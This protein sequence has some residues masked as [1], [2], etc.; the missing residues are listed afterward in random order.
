MAY[1]FTITQATNAFTITTPQGSAINVGSTA[2]TVSATQNGVLVIDNG[3]T[4]SQGSTGYIGSAGNQGYTGSAGSQG[5]AG[6]QGTTGYVGSQGLRGVGYP[7]ITGTSYQ[8][9]YGIGQTVS[10]QGDIDLFTTSYRNH[11]TV[12]IWTTQEYSSD[13]WIGTI[14]GVSGSSFG[15]RLVSV[16]GN[17]DPSRTTWTVGLGGA[18]GIQ[19][20]AGSQGA[21]GSTGTSI[22][23]KSSVASYSFLPIPGVKGD[24]YLVRDQGDLYY[25]NGSSYVDAGHIVGSQGYT[26]SAG[27]NGYTGSVGIGYVGSA[28]SY[29]QALYTTSSVTFAGLTLNNDNVILGNGSGLNPQTN[30]IAIGHQASFGGAQGDNTIAIGYQSGANQNAYA[31]AIGYQ[32]GNDNQGANA[33]AIGRNAGQYQQGQYA[34]AIGTYDGSSENAGAGQGEYS[35][36]IGAAAGEFNQGSNAVAIGLGAGRDQQTPNSIILNASGVPFNDSGNSGFYVN[37]VRSDN[38]PTDIIYFNSTTGELTYGAANPANP[39]DQVLYTTSSVTFDSVTATNIIQASQFRASNGASYTTGYSFYTETD[40]STG[41]YSEV[42]GQVSIYGYENPIATFNTS[43]IQLYQPLKFPDNTIQTSAFSGNLNGGVVTYNTTTHELIVNDTQI[44]TVNLPAESLLVLD[45]ATDSSTFAHTL[46]FGNSATTSGAINDPWS[47]ETPMLFFPSTGAPYVEV[48]YDN[49]LNF[50]ADDLTI[51]CWIYP[52]AVGND[53]GDNYSGI[54]GAWGYGNFM[55]LLNSDGLIYLFDAGQYPMIASTTQPPLNDWTHIA[56]T[57]AN[58][59]FTLWINGVAEGTYTVT[60]NDLTS[61][62]RLRIGEQGSDQKSFDGYITGVRMVDKVALYSTTFTPPV[63]GN[64]DYALHTYVGTTYT[65]STASLITSGII[66]PDSTV[67]TTAW[68]TATL[69]D[70]RFN[71]SWIRNKDTGNIYISPQDGQTWLYLPS[72]TDATTQAVTLSNVAGGGIQ[73]QTNNHIWQFNNNGS[74]TFPSQSTNNRTGSGDALVFARDGAGQKI[75]ATQS[76]DNS[77]STVERLVIAG[78]DGYASGEGGDIYLWA[79]KSG[80]TGGTGG[81]IKVDAGDAYDSQGGTV[82]IRGGNVYN[83]DNSIPGEGGFIQILAGHSYNGG[84]GGTITLAAGNGYNG[85]DNGKVIIQS[86]TGNWQFNSDGSITFPDNTTQTSAYT[87]SNN[88]FDQ[89]L[90]TTDIPTFS[91]IILNG[92]VPLRLGLDAGQTNQGANSIAIGYSAGGTNQTSGAVAIGDGAGSLNQGAGAVA[93]G[94]MAGNSAQGYGGTGQGASSVAIG[95]AAGQNDQGIYSVAI[96]PYAG[97]GAGGASQGNYSI[98]I[99]N[100]AGYTNQ[101][102]YS[103]A[104]GNDA[105]FENQTPNSIILNA[106]G[107]PFNDSGNAGFYVNPIRSATADNVIYFDSTTNELTY[108]TAI[109]GY[110]GSQGDI[111]YVGSQGDQ[112]IPGNDGGQGPQGDPG[113]VGSQGDIGYVGSQGDVGYVGSTGDLGYTGSQ[114]TPG[115]SVRI[116]GSAANEAGLSPFDPIPVIGDGVITT[117]TGHLWVYDGIQFNDVGNVTGPQG[118]QGYTGSQGDIGYVGSQGNIGY[119]GSVGIGYVGSAGGNGTNGYTG[120]QGT[121]GGLGYTGSKGADG[122][123]GSNGATGYTGSVGVGYVGSAG[124]NGSGNDT[125]YTLGNVSGTITPSLSSGTVH[126]YTLTGNIT[127]NSLT[128]VT[129]GSSMTLILTQDATGSRTLTSSMKWAG[130]GFKT[131]STAGTSTDIVSIFYDGSTYWASLSKGF[132]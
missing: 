24:L 50:G 70:I 54:I 19:G 108:G 88:P 7:V 27:T 91:T 87:G 3:Y 114:G 98:A 117:D 55:I 34:I 127:L 63:P 120:S 76:G 89:S 116:L 16:I 18:Q 80:P 105:G 122:T 60:S 77:Y 36:A 9:S 33:V 65:T 23:V 85:G 75:I 41:V 86:A 92:D 48:S 123:N 118:G 99:G 79:G 95:F 44:T 90:N 101:G 130:L 38:S 78:G 52:L 32:A 12:R 100:Q 30:T 2:T 113:Y 96:G 94:Y 39:F 47:T 74:L 119:V 40:Q 51:D 26:G 56:V 22:T 112:G 5:Y 14:D 104:I 109:T 43:T 13:G 132:Q 59:V 57:R 45:G 17:P 4:G 6:S 42:E 67:Q 25:Y 102:N 49:S 124:A 66:F 83:G 64:G 125:V 20:Y 21:N 115:T 29:D 82:K 58:N 31:V 93:L 128:G 121:T 62:N 111:G 35:I 103:I 81:D 68:T 61:I 37:P 8:L 1:Q 15:I 10:F 46:T 129:T 28:G 110:T 106:S 97:T 72:D 71:G 84:T 69:G 73:I 53:S 126:S 131:L 107:N 11:E